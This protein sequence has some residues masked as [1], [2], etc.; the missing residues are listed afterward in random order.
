MNLDHNIT[1]FYLGL[2]LHDACVG[3]H[4][5]VIK[6]LIEVRKCVVLVK[7]SNNSTPLHFASLSGQLKVVKYFIEELYKGY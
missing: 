6:Y 4:L 3:G 5:D 1:G 7:D 2:P